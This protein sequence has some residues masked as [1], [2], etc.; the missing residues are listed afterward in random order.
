MFQLDKIIQ[1]ARAASGEASN[2][3]SSGNL[4]FVQMPFSIIEPQA[5]VNDYQIIDTKLLEKD[6]HN[7]LKR[8]EGLSILDICDNYGINFIG[9]RILGGMGSKDQP[10]LNVD[11]VIGPSSSGYSRNI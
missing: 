1:I 7:L 8:A 11:R 9:H 3:D 5:W 4:K 2:S 10:I 6:G